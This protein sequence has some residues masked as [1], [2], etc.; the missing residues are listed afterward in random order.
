MTKKITLEE[1]DFDPELTEA[2]QKAMTQAE[3]HAIETLIKASMVDSQSPE[4]MLANFLAGVDIVTCKVISLVG[5]GNLEKMQGYAD[6]HCEN[7]QAF[8]LEAQR[9]K[10]E[11]V[12]ELQK[13]IKEK[14]GENT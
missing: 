11:V 3:A 12:E 2:S 10:A 13:T 8:M 6:M 4:H 14:K 5:S 9:L 1:F 7:V